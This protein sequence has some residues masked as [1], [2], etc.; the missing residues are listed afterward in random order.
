MIR[1]LLLDLDD[2]L[3]DYAAPEA[4]AKRALCTY[5][6]ERLHVTP[7]RAFELYDTARARVKARLGKRGSSH[8]RLLYL[9]ELWSAAG[10]PWST[11]IALAHEMYWQ[12][13]FEHVVWRPGAREFLAAWRDSGKKIAI[14]TDLVADVQLRKLSH[15]GLFSMI[16]AYAISEEVPD[17]KPARAIFE[18]AAERLNMPLAACAVIG[19]S[20]RADGDGARSLGL[21]FFRVAT[22]S[23]PDGMTFE[24]I[25]LALRPKGELT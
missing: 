2:T 8:S 18:L 24:E 13:Y 21:P 1:A 11:E 5:V 15:L 3:Y 22:S 4:A 6:A 7:E 23:T 12:T 25:A 10:A 20:E 19:D 14:V 16:D 9:C 17:D